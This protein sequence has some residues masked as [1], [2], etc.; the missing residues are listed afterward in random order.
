MKLKLFLFLCLIFLNVDLNASKYTDNAEENNA[1]IDAFIDQLQRE[2]PEAK[3]N[4]DRINDIKKGSLKI[5]H[6][7]S[8]RLCSQE[9]FKKIIDLD[10][11][12]SLDLSL[13]IFKE[14][15]DSIVNL[16]HLEALNLSAI[17]LKKLPD[18]SNL[19]N[20]IRL[21][22]SANSLEEFPVWITHLKSLKELNLR[23]NGIKFVPDEICDLTNLTY[24]HLGQNGLTSLPTNI[25]NLENLRFLCVESNKI[26]SIPQSLGKLLQLEDLEVYGNNLQGLPNI[27]FSFFKKLKKL[28][29]H[30]NPFDRLPKSLKTLIDS[31]S[32]E[33]WYNFCKN[34]YFFDLLLN[35]CE[36]RSLVDT[37]YNDETD[38]N[39][40]D[41]EKQSFEKLEYI[42]GGLIEKH[43]RLKT[44]F[45][46]II[47]LHGLYAVLSVED[48]RLSHIP[49]ILKQIGVLINCLKIPNTEMD[50]NDNIFV[51][52]RE[53][54]HDG[55]DLKEYY[56]PSM[57]RY[58]CIKHN[59]IF[60]AD[61]LFDL[62]EML[63][64]LQEKNP[65]ADHLSAL[66]KEQ[67]NLL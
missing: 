33:N 28:E 64:D 7:P 31:K 35:Y 47:E 27:G 53:F 26:K 52:S 67:K 42:V 37:E 38:L 20:L 17:H 1:K 12:T 39:I 66:L 24:L 44:E 57:G 61:E 3:I 13:C 18:L 22:L 36:F 5:A 46:D 34:P 6:Y 8:M 49:E 32:K 25:G 60:P 54:V 51:Q 15:P 23:A 41:L 55:I 14:L 21:D 48:I 4:V 62:M 9:L 56:L 40:E 16:I 43:N 11:L 50:H 65:L 59:D 58:F 10:W 2:N 29:L 45:N 30:K 19:V 63:K